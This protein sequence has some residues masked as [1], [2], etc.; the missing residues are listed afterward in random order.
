MSKNNHS[1]VWAK[2]QRPKLNLRRASSGEVE[3]LISSKFNGGFPVVLSSGRG[4]MK[5]IVQEFW[6]EKDI[7]IFQFASQCVVTSIQAASVTPYSRTDFTSE[8]IYHQ[9]GYS[10]LNG[11]A[12]PFIEDSCDTFLEEGS[13]VL[14]LGGQ[15]EIWSLPKILSSRFGAIVWCLNAKDAQHLRAI[16]D[17]AKKFDV[18]KK[19]IYRSLRQI[20]SSSYQIWENSEYK[21]FK[22][23]KK[24]YGLIEK[25]ILEWKEKY[26][27]RLDLL[28]QAYSFLNDK[29]REYYEKPQNFAAS[30]KLKFA[31]VVIVLDS[32]KPNKNLSAE[33]AFEI[34]HRIESGKKPE[35][36]MVYKLLKDERLK[37]F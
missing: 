17:K 28:N 16:R 30:E 15:F 20:N 13:S 4:A 22:L 25:D 33:S 31:P 7:S 14:R 29:Y 3:D 21:T 11:K 12:R 1:G 27:E 2:R 10:D 18:R 26:M 24:E 8:V 19:Q 35:K 23:S 5:L 34:L 32:E 9:W 36:Y 6:T 37:C